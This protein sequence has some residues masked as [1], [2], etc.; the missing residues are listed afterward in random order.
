MP[1]PTITDPF[2]RTLYQRLVEEIDKR[3]A[4]LVDGGSLTF[5]DKGV[6]DIN[7]TA[8]KYQKDISYLEA[9]HQVLNLGIQLDHDQY[10]VRT[11][12]DDGE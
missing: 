12:E 11:K 9:L 8:M 5:S 1:G 3:S 2:F 4:V 7:A 6:I 10:G